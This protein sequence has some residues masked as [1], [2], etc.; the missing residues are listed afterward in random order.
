MLGVV[1]MVKKAR[2]WKK[3]VACRG[4]AKRNRTWVGARLGAWSLRI[5]FSLVFP[6]SLAARHDDTLLHVLQQ[7]PWRAARLRTVSYVFRHSIRMVCIIEALYK[8]SYRY[9]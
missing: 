9:F 1:R 2:A 3:A 6:G 8:Q 7:I 5:P 4:F